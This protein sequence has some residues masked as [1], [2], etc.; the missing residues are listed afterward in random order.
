MLAHQGQNSAAQET[1]HRQ[2]QR[3][4]LRRVEIDRL[5]IQGQCL[6]VVAHAAQHGG[7]G[8]G[9]ERTG[10]GESWTGAGIVCLRETADRQIVPALPVLQQSAS[11]EQAGIGQGAGCLLRMGDFYHL[12]RRGDLAFVVDVFS[13]RREEIHSQRVLVPT[14]IFQTFGYRL[15]SRGGQLQDAERL[16]LDHVQGCE[17]LMIRMR[18]I[19]FGLE[20]RLDPGK[21]QLGILVNQR[22]QFANSRIRAR[23]TRGGG[24]QHRH[25]R[26]TKSTGS[27]TNH[28]ARGARRLAYVDL[29]MRMRSYGF[30][31]TGSIPNVTVLNFESCATRMQRGPTVTEFA[32]TRRRV[33]NGEDDNCNDRGHIG[34]SCPLNNEYIGIG[35][36]DHWFFCTGKYRRR[37]RI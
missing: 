16:C 14:R 1:I 25:T 33:M 20:Q 5:F 6:V 23:Q 11:D 24:R 34:I 30:P 7:Q 12:I 19:I 28:A 27:R 3:R 15:T 29:H 31:A 26:G 36:Y 2:L 35:L 32:A 18:Q 13:Q 9:G 21:G 37:S 10:L 4:I 8:T 22:L 17:P